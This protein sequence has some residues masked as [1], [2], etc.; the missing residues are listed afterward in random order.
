MIFFEPSATPH[1]RLATE[2]GD[3]RCLAMP[4]DFPVLPEPDDDEFDQ[5][6]RLS[7][8]RASFP[9]ERQLVEFRSVFDRDPQSDSELEG[10]VDEFTREMY[11]SGYDEVPE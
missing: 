8:L 7:Q 1:G 6:D 10:F 2:R 9:Y 3:V 4:R 5:P 11:N